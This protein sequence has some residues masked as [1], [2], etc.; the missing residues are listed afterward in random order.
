MTNDQTSARTAE[1]WKIHRGSTEAGFTGLIGPLWARQEAG[2]WA[3]AFAAEVRHTNRSGVLHGGMLMSFIDHALGLMVWEAVDR[4]NCTT[5]GLN[6]QFVAPARPG[7][8]LE[9]RGRVIRRTRSL[10][11]V[12]GGITCGDR[13][14]LV[15]DGIW[16][17][18]GEN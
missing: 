17:I 13:E 8:W 4:R 2:G 16:K 10:V 3:Y 7:D 18:I 12:Q 11:F 5:V 9:A 6:H 1:G 15:A 14:I